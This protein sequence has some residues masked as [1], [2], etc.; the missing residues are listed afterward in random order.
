M[1]NLFHFWVQDSHSWL[2]KT[3]QLVPLGITDDH[4][5]FFF[6][7]V[8]IIILYF[9]FKPMISLMIA[10][11]WERLLSFLVAGFFLLFLMAA[12]EM[13][14]AETGT[15]D[16]EFTDLSSGSVAIMFFGVVLIA[17]HLVELVVR[18]MKKNNEKVTK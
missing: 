8:G 17:T 4:L 18:L 9:G 13:Y 6:G 15:G 14:Q 16:L 5:H 10:L 2:V 3:A 12:F 7:G 11:N 1:G